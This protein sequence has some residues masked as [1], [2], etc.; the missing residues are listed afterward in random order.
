MQRGGG[1]C[2]LS[3][4]WCESWANSGSPWG[5][6]GGPQHVAY[7]PVNMKHAKQTAQSDTAETKTQRE[8]AEN[9]FHEVTD[10]GRG[11]SESRGDAVE[12]GSVA[13]AETGFRTRPRR[14]S[15]GCLSDP[16]RCG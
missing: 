7:S 15:A 14:R 3:E 12:P 1:R 10:P 8:R 11:G 4:C 16:R 9:Q 13:E 2:G 6:T 5:M